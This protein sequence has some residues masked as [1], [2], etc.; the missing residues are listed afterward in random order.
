MSN[1]IKMLFRNTVI[2]AKSHK[3]WKCFCFPRYEHWSPPPKKKSGKISIR[4]MEFVVVSRS[5]LPPFD[6][7]LLPPK[8]N[9]KCFIF[10]MMNFNFLE[11]CSLFILQWFHMWNLIIHFIVLSMDIEF[12]SPWVPV[13]IRISSRIGPISCLKHPV[14]NLIYPKEMAH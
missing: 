10:T 2:W 4:I 3:F 11:L 13:W 12:N 14:N 8:T 1:S 6:Q 9:S 5:S 7:M